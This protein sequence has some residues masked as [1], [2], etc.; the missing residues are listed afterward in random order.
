MSVEKEGIKGYEYQYLA[1]LYFSLMYLEKDDLEIYIEDTEDAKISFIEADINNKIYLQ[2]KKHN[3]SISTK[4]MCCWLRHFGDRQS[5]EFLLSRIS[6]NNNYVVFISEGRCNDEVSKFIRYSEFHCQS[7]CKFSREYLNKLEEELSKLNSRNSPLDKERNKCVS[8]FLKKGSKELRNILQRVSVMELLTSEILQKKIREL[9]STKFLV[10]PGDVNNVVHLLDECI[11]NGRDSGKDITKEIQEIIS[12]FSQ[13]ILPSEIDYIPIP[14]QKNYEEIL[15]KQHVLLITGMAFCGKTSTAKAIAQQYAQQGYE[16]RQTSDLDGDFGALSFLNKYSQDKRLL[17]LEDP[18]GSVELE[19]G[20][21][22][23]KEKICKLVVESASADRKFIVTTRLDLLLKGFN[24][25]TITECNIAEEHKWFD[26]S[27]QDIEFAKEYWCNVYSEQKT[28]SE[29]FNNFLKWM[30]TKKLGIFLE[31]GE[32]NN[33]KRKYPLIDVLRKTDYQAVFD[34]ARISS[35]SIVEKLKKEDEKVILAYIALGCCC[36]TARGVTRDNLSF[37]L[38]KSTEIPAIISE[39]SNGTTGYFSFRNEENN[40]IFPKYSEKYDL[41][42]SIF[43]GFEKQGY[44]SRDK[45]SGKIYFRHPVFCHASKLLFLDELKFGWEPE[46]LLLLVEHGVSVLDKNNNLCALDIISY[47]FE[48]NSDFND[49]ILDILFKAL[50]SIF[51]ATK[52]KLV[53]LIEQHFN[54]LSEKQQDRFVDVLREYKDYEYQ[55][56]LWENDEPFIHPDKKNGWNFYRENAIN[57]EDVKKIN[58]K[59]DCTPKKMYEILYSNFSNNLPIEFLKIS[60]MYEESFIRAKAAYLI[61]K[62]HANC[63]HDIDIFLTDTDN[64]NVTVKLMGG[65]LKA[66]A[67]FNVA[68]RE[69]ILEYSFR[70]LKRLS[71]AIQIQ[72]Y[73]DNFWD[74]YASWGLN[75]DK[76]D[77]EYKK[78]LWSVWCRMYTEFFNIFPPKYLRMDGAHMENTMHY[79]VEKVE[80]YNILLKLFTAWNKWLLRCKEPSDFEMCIMRYVLKYLPEALPGRK[81][82]IAKMLEAKTTSIIASHTK[83]IVDNWNITTT[84]EKE[85]FIKLLRSDRND[86]IWIKAV[87]LTRKTV[88]KDI[89]ECICREIVFDESVDKIVKVLRDLKLLEPCLNVYCGYPQPLEWNGYSHSNYNYNVWDEIISEVIKGD[90]IDKAFEIAL[91]E[92]ISCEYHKENRFEKMRDSIWDSILSTIEK[93]KSF[94]KRLHRISCTSFNTNKE[95]WDRYFKFS[96]QE[97]KIEAYKEIASFIE[98]LEYFNNYNNRGKGILEIFG[99]KIIFD[100]LYP[101]LQSDNEIK[102]ICDDILKICKYS[103]IDEKYEF[104]KAYGKI[105]EEIYDKLP[106]RM[107]LTNFIVRNTMKE[108]KFTDNRISQ[109]LEKRQEELDEISKKQR[110]ELNDNYDLENW[111]KL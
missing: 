104:F 33:L 17:L 39:H 79:A 36:D 108:I 92:F 16:I 29:Y 52:D 67:D 5:N 85:Q 4:D 10:K 78:E 12:K 56:I 59:Q 93:R 14:N 109:I 34:D 64:A 97:E 100:E 80:D 7:S 54:N 84:N 19:E 11:R 13:R 24:K 73:L 71:V 62:H 91:R 87:A 107:Q 66:W 111:N 51:P 53:L 41:D 77:E 42:K 65:A 48:K 95:L 69:K 1:T 55:Y 74:P 58:N 40:P 101:L 8:D 75:W 72:R 90:E 2:I 50:D 18:F 21:L 83:H 49:K 28:S 61:F 68:Q 70:N 25:K 23:I 26:Q 82:L 94:F 30:Q 96:S 76:Y 15:N 47:C 89:Q 35:Q 6:E 106:P 88:F 37:V 105:I 63:I 43:K 31:I 20:A 27:M 60:M 81:E 98:A 3:Q 38:S 103:N 86:V 32:I 46:K 110:K 22:E 45:I 44:I 9:L 99:G 102:S 57:M